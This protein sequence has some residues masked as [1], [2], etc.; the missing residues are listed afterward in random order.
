MSVPEDR[1]PTCGV[2]FSEQ[3]ASDNCPVPEQHAP[4]HVIWELSE[5]YAE[6]MSAEPTPEGS[7]YRQNGEEIYGWFCIE[8]TP[9]PRP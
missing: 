8:G 2:P 5:G 7:L 4:P 3:P 6:G 9:S 1:C